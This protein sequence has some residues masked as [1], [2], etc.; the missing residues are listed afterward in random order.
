MLLNMMLFFLRHSYRFHIL[1]HNKG[2]DFS[3]VCIYYKNNDLLRDVYFLRSLVSGSPDELTHS[4]LRK[5]R[6]KALHIL[7]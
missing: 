4:P 2:V 1:L 6:L 5:T 7:I 3:H